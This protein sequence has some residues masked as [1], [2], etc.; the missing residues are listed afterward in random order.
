MYI[1]K[2]MPNHTIYIKNEFIM[3]K[4]MNE[5]IRKAQCYEFS[6]FLHRNFYYIQKGKKRTADVVKEYLDSIGESNNK[7]AFDQLLKYAKTEVIKMQQASER[8]REGDWDS[9]LWENKKVRIS[10]SEL[11]NIIR[12]SIEEIMTGD[13]I[14]QGIDKQWAD[15]NSPLRQFGD[16]WLKMT[17]DLC[18]KY[19]STINPQ[20]LISLMKPIVVKIMMNK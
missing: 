5:G 16:E 9:F 7:S 10:E 18:N 4:K 14:N 20:E 1:A 11:K 2:F 13:Y 3:K 17:M 19:N 15:P 8:S 12:E 6:D